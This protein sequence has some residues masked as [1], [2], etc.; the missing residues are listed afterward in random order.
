MTGTQFLQSIFRLFGKDI[1]KLRNQGAIDIPDMPKEKYSYFDEET[2]IAESLAALKVQ[3]TF[4][5]DMAAGDGV[6]QS[7]TYRL[8]LNGWSGLAVEGS[9][10]RFATLSFMLK[11]YPKVVLL[12]AM[13]SPEN[14]C[15]LLAGHG[16][17]Q[18]FAFLNL[19]MDGYD[20][21]VLDKILTSYRPPLI[22]A[23]INEMIPPPLR[24]SVT[25]SP[26][27]GWPGDHFFGQSISQ[28][29]QL[30]IQHGYVITRLEY[31]NAFL[32]PKEISPFSALSP[33]QAYDAGYRNRPERKS[34]FLSNGD[35]EELLWL[36]PDKALSFVNSLFAKYKGRY[37]C[38]I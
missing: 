9:G 13:V 1:I 7:N 34:K 36:P 32:V 5:V 31:N 14:V 35:V 16:V 38:E 12:R 6:T 21:F 26:E 18:R 11:N 20:Y 28:L 10:S 17:H 29:H 3:D 25:Y 27:F 33:E 19:D 23:E 15:S 22:C 37:S 2:I 4:C 8:F 24:F 30:C